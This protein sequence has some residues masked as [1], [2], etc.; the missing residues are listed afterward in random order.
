MQRN[1]HIETGDA[2]TDTETPG[3]RLKTI[4]RLM[5]S[6]TEGLPD[7]KQGGRNL[8]TRILDR[9]F[10]AARYYVP[11]LHWIGAATFAIIFFAYARLVAVTMRLITTGHIRWP[12]IPLPCV[13]AL[14][15]GDAPS[16]LVAFAKRR[17]AVDMAIMIASD[18]RGDFLALLCRMLGLEVVR[19][20]GAENGWQALVALADKIEQGASV[21]ITVDGGGPAHVVK[22]GALALAS[23]T[24]IPLVAL[25]TNCRPA[26]VE[27]RKWDAARNPLPFARVAVAMGK[28]RTIGPLDG[29]TA[30]QQESDVL[31]LALDELTVRSKQTLGL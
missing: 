30:I 31:Q 23:A 7:E 11:P 20:G 1:Y 25:A 16:L 18:S 13:V 9:F 24:Q 2:K 4:E 8:F 28:P 27:W 5:S 12:S 14:W 15:H 21:I 10:A 26:I 19:G 6:S 22:V 3:D 17:P 29:F